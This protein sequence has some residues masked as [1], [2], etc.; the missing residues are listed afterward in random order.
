MVWNQ[1]RAMKEWVIYH[2]WLG[3]EKWYIYDNNS[4]D[5]IDDVVRE[6]EV[7]GYNINRVVWPWIKSQEAGFSHCSLRAKE[8]CK[9]VCL[10][11]RCGFIFY[12]AYSLLNQDF[13]C[14]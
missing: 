1:A 4:D 11:M 8:E 3:V 6:L 10:L 13:C 5:E 9:W 2:A 14:T 7:K 12:A